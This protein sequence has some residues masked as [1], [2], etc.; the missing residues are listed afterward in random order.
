MSIVD[1]YYNNNLIVSILLYI[2][3]YALN[4]SIINDGYTY[5]WMDNYNESKQKLN[6]IK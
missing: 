4:N 1:V 6:C 3:L 2:M 5:G